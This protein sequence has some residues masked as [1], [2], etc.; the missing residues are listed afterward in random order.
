MDFIRGDS[1]TYLHL[2]ERLQIS[3]P[4]YISHSKKLAF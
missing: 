2:I 4:P 1:N 3:P